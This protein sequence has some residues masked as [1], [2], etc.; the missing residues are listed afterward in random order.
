MQWTLSIA[1][2]LRADEMDY[3]D[4]IVK[5]V[6]SEKTTYMKDENKYVFRV[7]MN[8]NK[9]TVK[10]A[11]KE[12]FKVNPI[13]VNILRIRGKRKKVRYHYGYTAGWK[14]AIVTLQKG[15]KIELFENQ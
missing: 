8:A 12:L 10:K 15:D 7:S 14:K 1:S 11:V 9:H 4:I 13:K 5:P 2:I 3:N 6:I